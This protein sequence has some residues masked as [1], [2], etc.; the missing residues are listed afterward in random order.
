MCSLRRLLKAGDS[1]HQ[2]LDL[3]PSLTVQFRKLVD[4]YQQQGKKINEAQNT[5]R[6]LAERDMV[7]ANAA[8]EPARAS[9]AQVLAIAD[10]PLEQEC[11][12][13]M[14]GFR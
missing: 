10:M 11:V 6:R 14:T 7:G 5:W 12:S 2:R 13:E 4:K 1:W 3:T 9:T 8:A